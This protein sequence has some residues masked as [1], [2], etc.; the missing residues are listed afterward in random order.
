MVIIKNFEVVVPAHTDAVFNVLTDI[1]MHLSLWSIYDSLQSINKNEA[2][3]NLRIAGSLYVI[4]LKIRTEIVGETRVVDFEGQGDL[5][6][7]LRL[8]LMARGMYT[9]I[10]GRFLVKSSFFRERILSSALHSFIEDYRRK[11]MIELPLMVEVLT[12]KEA[13]KPLKE[14]TAEV[15]LPEPS[16]PGSPTFEEKFAGTSVAVKPMLPAPPE[17]VKEEAKVQIVEDPRALEDELKLSVLLL[18]SKLSLTKRIK[19]TAVEVLNEAWKIRDETKMLILFISTSSIEGHKIRL[20]FKDKALIGVRLELS[21][22]TFFNGKEAL[23]KI[24]ELTNNVEW[25]MYVYEVPPE[26]ASTLEIK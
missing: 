4:R 17:V 10:T 25:R 3:V 1:A 26:V 6:L 14:G 16:K 7:S 20:L 13:V 8:T 22:G 15:L 19:C 11:L 24:R 5:Y 12:K 9:V 21:D 23:N 2:V 18:K